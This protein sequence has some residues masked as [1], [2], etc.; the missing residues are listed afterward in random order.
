MFFAGETSIRSF[1]AKTLF[2]SLVFRSLV[3]PRDILPQ[4]GLPPPLREPRP[5]DADTDR[6]RK[7]RTN[8]TSSGA[9]GNQTECNFGF[10]EF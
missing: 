6:A 4:F 8:P 1:P 7:F 2:C 3:F 5:L 9:E 10:V